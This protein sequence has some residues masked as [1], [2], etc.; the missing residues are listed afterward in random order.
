LLADR[1]NQCAVPVVLLRGA[2]PHRV[3]VPVEQRTLLQQ[4]LRRF[5]IQDVPGAGQY[6]QEEQ[7][8]VVVAA[9]KRLDG[10]AR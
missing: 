10:V 4:K 9:V 1:L 8:A 6:I 5:W 2:A 7:P 3:E